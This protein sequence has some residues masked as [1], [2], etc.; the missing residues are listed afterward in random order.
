MVTLHKM[1]CSIGWFR[2][3]YVY[4]IST[5]LFKVIRQR[6]SFIK[7]FMLRP[8]VRI[9]IIPDLAIFAFHLLHNIIS[10][11]TNHILVQYLILW[12]IGALWSG[13]YQI[14]NII[15]IISIDKVIITIISE[16]FEKMFMKIFSVFMVMHIFQENRKCVHW[17]MSKVVE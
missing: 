11:T 12:C 6:V 1:F 8:T 9:R 3:T 4:F 16:I 2:N 10:S 7:H 5:I 17:L 14:K 15:V 13:M